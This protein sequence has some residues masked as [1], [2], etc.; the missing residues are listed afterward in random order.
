MWNSATKSAELVDYV[1]NIPPDERAAARWLNNRRRELW[2]ERIEHDHQGTVK[3][4]ALIGIALEA[5]VDPTA[6]AA[7]KQ[8]EAT[9]V[10]V[11]GPNSGLVLQNR[12]KAQ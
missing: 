7:G 5:R 11:H 12:S 8:I 9:A 3:L 1:E 6:T 2:A 4:S 10:P